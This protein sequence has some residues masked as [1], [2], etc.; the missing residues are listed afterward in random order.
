MAKRRPKQTE[1]L[2]HQQQ[3]E[4]DKSHRPIRDL[5]LLVL[6]VALA[7][8]STRSNDPLVV[9]PVLLTSL[10]GLVV[11]CV[12]YEGPRAWRILAGILGAAMLVWVGVRAWPPP[13]SI[14]GHAKIA[15]AEIRPA[16]KEAQVKGTLPPPF[17]NIY[18]HNIGQ[19]AAD[20]IV[21][22]V[23]LSPVSNEM[24]NASIIAEQDKLLR[25]D[26]WKA[27]MES[28]NGQE[29]QPGDSGRFISVPPDPGDPRAGVLKSYLEW[30][31][32]T[33]RLYVLITD[34]YIDRT[35]PPDH[36]IVTERCSYFIG[37]D[38]ADHGCGRNRV[39]IERSK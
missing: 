14:E 39:F 10:I 28:R 38:T 8:V 2:R 35:L 24:D 22:Q 19:L 25:L 1:S 26:D 31:V 6:T 12:V 7:V 4:K 29:M 18:F 33:K 9:Y 20:Q 16:Y 13:D 27:W 11:L 37:D 5:V 23:V 17:V 36:H 34:K 21:D 3:S 15:V 30:G 32:P